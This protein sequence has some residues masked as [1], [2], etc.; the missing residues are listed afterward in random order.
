M[1]HLH[2]V[3]FLESAAI[4]AKIKQY[5]KGG[6]SHDYNERFP[7]KY[8]ELWHNEFVKIINDENILLKVRGYI[9]GNLLKHKEINNFS[10]LYN[11]PFTSYKYFADAHG[12]Q[13]AQD[14]IGE[15]I[16]VNENAYGKVDLG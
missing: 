16:V 14:L 8:P 15:V 10:D 6:I 5:L 7:K 11:C 3:L 4:Y 1:N 12:L 2:F 9:I 13:V